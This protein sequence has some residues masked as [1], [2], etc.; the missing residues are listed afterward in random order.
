[1]LEPPPD[2]VAKV[3]SVAIR[4]GEVLRYVATVGL[5]PEFDNILRCREISR[6]TTSRAGQTALQGRVV[7][8]EDLAS[9]HHCGF[10]EAVKLNGTRT[11]MG[12]FC[13]AKARPSA[14][15]RLPAT[16]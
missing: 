16:T 7:Q 13:C 2:S 12:Y 9:D 4:Q 5:T 10:P 14:S 11:V 1:M 6:E 3:G 15:S 8:I